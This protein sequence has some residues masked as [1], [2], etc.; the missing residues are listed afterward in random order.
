M[1]PWEEKK[2]TNSSKIVI[3]IQNYNIPKPSAWAMATCISTI[4][5]WWT[6]IWKWWLKSHT[7]T[8][9]ISVL[10]PTLSTWI[11]SST[12]KKSYGR[13]RMMMNDDMTREQGMALTWAILEADAF[14][15]YM[16][17][18]EYS[19]ISLRLHVLVWW[20]DSGDLLDLS[21]ILFYLYN[22][23]TIG[24]QRYDA[25]GNKLM[26]ED[27]SR[28]DSATLA[29]DKRLPNRLGYVLFGK[30]E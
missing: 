14:V 8:S 27:G 16:W 21:T 6:W 26:A 18:L 9:W 17:N 20:E 19:L 5:T 1:H 10:S 22:S 24:I 25:K 2:H 3:R 4:S 28:C 11:T 23:P 15:L 13:V 7:G 12:A 29:L 30:A